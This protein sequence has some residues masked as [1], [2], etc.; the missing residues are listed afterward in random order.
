M[1]K[2]NNWRMIVLIGLL[3]FLTGSVFAQK[4]FPDLDLIQNRADS[5]IQTGNPRKAIILLDSI[6]RMIYSQSNHYPLVDLLA[7]YYQTVRVELRYRREELANNTL[8]GYNLIKKKIKTPQQFSMA[9]RYL[10]NMGLIFKRL[11]LYSKSESIYREAY[12]KVQQMS[13]PNPIYAGSII[14]N[15]AYILTQTGDFITSVAYSEQA[16]RYLDQALADT[17][18]AS[19]FPIIRQSK[20]TAIMN[21]TVA[22][23]KM[24]DHQRVVTLLEKL[25]KE[26]RI[27]NPDDL[28]RIRLNLAL[29][30]IELD[31]VSQSKKLLYDIVH[32]NKAGSANK[33]LMA[34]AMINLA[35][36]SVRFDRDTA[37]F[38]VLSNKI[39]R[40]LDSQPVLYQDLLITID[41]LTGDVSIMQKDF[42]RAHK[43]VRNM[44]RLLLREDPE[45]LIGDSLNLGMVS[46][47]QKIMVLNTLSLQA[48]LWYQWGHYEQD[49]ERIRDAYRLYT[50]ASQLTNIWMT[51]MS[52]RESKLQVSRLQ[53]KIYNQLV[54]IGYLLYTESKD[55]TYLEQ[56]FGFFEQSKASG[57]WNEMQGVE[58]QS[59]FISEADRNLERQIKEEISRLEATLFDMRSV[60]EPD[61]VSLQQ[62]ENELF[63]Q[64]NRLDSLH[65]HIKTEYPELFKN[66]FDRTTL[67]LQQIRQYLTYDQVM[68]QYYFTDTTLYV[69]SVGRQQLS[70][71]RITEPDSLIN[72]AGFLI[73][74]TRGSRPY[75]NQEACEKYIVIAQKL[76]QNLLPGVNKMKDHAGLIVIPDGILNLLPFEIL[77]T[78]A[79]ASGQ[80]DYRFLAYLL[81]KQTVTY[82]YTATLYYHQRKD[83]IKSSRELLAIAPSY[84]PDQTDFEPDGLFARIISQMPDLAGTRKEVKAISHITSETKR[85]GR[86]ATERFFKQHASEY[87]ILH[88]AMHTYLNELDPQNSCLVFTPGADR[89]EDGLLFAHELDNLNLNASLAVLSACN[90]GSG[91]LMM[92]E[93]VLSLARGFIYS[94]CKNLIITLWKVDDNAGESIMESF[95]QKLKRGQTISSA[96]SNSK[97]DY[98]DHADSNFAHPFFW[99]GFIHLGQDQLIHLTRPFKFWILLVLFGIFL[100][101]LSGYEWYQHRNPRH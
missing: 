79:P 2:N 72:D 43:T 88:L 9:I 70:V 1:L 76:Y 17:T 39:H 92:G 38:F 47:D 6:T 33:R 18:F 48:N 25:L 29:S 74:L 84:H 28:D 99:A 34:Q 5:L 98:I 60:A 26:Q 87:D 7:F 14:S 3:G 11:H 22:L 21:L 55:S 94:G 49:Q 95:Y 56:M 62:I 51:E 80:H 52:N 58:L 63:V 8:D 20:G 73:R 27:Q 100:L 15:L 19:Y 57:L 54:E 85:T 4:N 24:G 41:I 30:L 35:D 83:Q 45:A 81:R 10:N 31:S 44:T 75:R 96:L 64:N 65:N 50:Q 91:K 69:M 16:I 68:W 46:P 61:E 66:R 36:I 101:G 42:K 59:E 53:K 23:Q 71:T 13:D 82:G 86:H 93:G 89:N 40:Q 77:L 12:D 32:R 97:L 37:E 78:E 67:T 90:T